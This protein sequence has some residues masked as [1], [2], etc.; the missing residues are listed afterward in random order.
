MK[1]AGVNVAL[2]TDGVSSNNNLDMVEEMKFAAILHNGAGCDPLAL[3]APDALR[4][5]TVNGAKALGRNTGRI[6]VDCDADL[7][8]LDSGRLNLIPCHNPVSNLAYA[9]HGG[10]VRMNMARGKVIYKDG[11][12][13]TIDIARVKREVAEYAV[14]L[15][16]G[17]K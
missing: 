16:F 3:L 5:A 8:L 12:F 6:A 17:A 15:L 13:L 4:M 9:A 2:G 7:N 11:D 1:K 14:P 10:D